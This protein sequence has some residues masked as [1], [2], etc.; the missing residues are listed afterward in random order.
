[1]P[2]NGGNARLCEVLLS[3]TIWRRSFTRS[4]PESFALQAH[5]DKRGEH[6]A[7]AF[8]SDGDLA[9]R[10]AEERASE[11]GGSDQQRHGGDPE[12]DRQ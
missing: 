4:C 7:D 1:M 9:D 11:S 10:H 6:D 2:Q 5:Q 12:I 8:H 3:A